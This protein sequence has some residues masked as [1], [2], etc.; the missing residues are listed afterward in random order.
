[1]LSIRKSVS[2]SGFSLLFLADLLFIG[3]L[4]ELLPKII[5]FPAYLFIQYLVSG[6]I[7][8]TQLI[9]VILFQ[10][11]SLSIF[12]FYTSRLWC[13]FTHNKPFKQDK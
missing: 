13:K 5:C 2:L 12:L 11:F 4:P 8:L 10:W 9:L 7:D 3:F 6:H 1:M